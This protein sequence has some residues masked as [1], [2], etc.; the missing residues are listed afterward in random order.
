EALAGAL[1]VQSA[2]KIVNELVATDR[3]TDSEKYALLVAWDAVLGL[4]LEREVR[5]A[6]EPTAEMREIMAQRDRARDA[7]DYATGDELRD[8]L[9]EMGLEVMD[10]SDGTKV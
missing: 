1:A 10:T 2:V 3:V 8:R 4:D 7:R 9:A 6:W 5:E